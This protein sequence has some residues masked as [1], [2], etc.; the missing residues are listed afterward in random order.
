MAEARGLNARIAI[1]VNPDVDAKTHH[2]IATGKAENKFGVP[3]AEAPALYRLASKLPNIEA[4]GV[5]MHIGSQITDLT[6]FQNAF[7][8]LKELVGT[9]RAQGV[10]ICLRQSRRRARHPLSPRPAAPRR[11]LPTM[12]ASSRTR[13]AISACGCCSSPGA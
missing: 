7:A 1:R 11:L 10:G 8:L 6:P 13:S 12:R 3:F 2:K 4:T 5:H 9:L